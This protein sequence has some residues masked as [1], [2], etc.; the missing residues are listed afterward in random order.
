MSHHYELLKGI[1]TVALPSIKRI[2]FHSLYTVMTTS[3]NASNAHIV[4]SPFIFLPSPA[5]R[6]E[7]F[8][9]LAIHQEQ[10]LPINTSLGPEETRLLVTTALLCIP[11]G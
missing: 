3:G 2:D 9:W 11:V 1:L 8:R 10:A 6:T 5:F 7:V 4:N